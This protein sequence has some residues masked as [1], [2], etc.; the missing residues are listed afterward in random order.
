MKKIVYDLIFLFCAAVIMVVLTNVL[1]SNDY[2]AFSFLPVLIAYGVGQ[3]IQRKF[4]KQG[5]K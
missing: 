3:L 2:I 1:S 4:G 5:E